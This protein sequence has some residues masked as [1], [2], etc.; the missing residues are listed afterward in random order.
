[1]KNIIWD[2]NNK[3][4]KEIYII[5]V[6]ISLFVA[7]IFFSEKYLS[8]E[9][10]KNVKPTETEVRAKLDTLVLEGKLTQLE[11][12]T[13]LEAILSGEKKGKKRGMFGKKPTEIEVRAKLDTLVLEGKL[14]QLEAETKLEAILSGEKKGKKRGMFSVKP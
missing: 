13:K 9:E 1:M 12:E 2:H 4:R 5:L 8:A 3:L 11:A 14:T 7:A 10:I 6:S